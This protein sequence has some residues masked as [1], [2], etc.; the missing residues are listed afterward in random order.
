[1]SQARHGIWLGS[2]VRVSGGY[3][4]F[5]PKGKLFNLPVPQFLPVVNR[6]DDNRVVM[7]ISTHK[8]VRQCLCES[9]MC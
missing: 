2:N 8:V 7:G 6:C 9:A 5:R 4:G 1:M 3:S